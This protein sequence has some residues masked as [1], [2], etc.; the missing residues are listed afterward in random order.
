MNIDDFFYEHPVFRLDELIAW[1]LEHGADNKRAV[2]AQL[3]YYLNSGRLLLVRRKLY[4]VVPP[5]TTPQELSV[6]PYL[7]AAKISPDSILG[8]H[9]ALEL[10][11]YAYSAFSRFTYFSMHEPKAFEFQNQRFQ[12][13]A[14]PANLKLTDSALLEVETINRQGIDIRFTSP[15]RTFVDVLN[16]VELVGGWEEVVRSISSMATLPIDRVIAYCIKL[17]N[18]VLFAKVGYFLEQRQDLFAPT[19]EQ[20][21]KLLQRKPSASQYLSR[22]PGESCRL[23]KKWNI[24]M[25]I[26]VIEQHWEEPEHDI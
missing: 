20:L 4:A 8:L 5:K 25:P 2:Q 3:Q 12:P 14:T 24:M 9:T 16:R 21:N 7:I 22:N 18:T 13:I 26:S 11:G 6:D 19:D 15:A 10:L 23:I 17:D 1:R